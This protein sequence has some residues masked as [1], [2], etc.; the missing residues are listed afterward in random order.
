MLNDLFLEMA[1][2]I[3]TA[4]VISLLLYKLRQPLIVAY[5]ITGIIVGAS[6]LRFTETLH[7]FEILSTLGISF[8][9]FIVGLNLNWRHIRGVGGVALAGGLAQVVLSS[10]IGYFIARALH[11]DL[12]TSL[13][14]GI[15]FAFSSTIIIVKI[16]TD[17]EDIDR[18]YGRIAVGI[19]IV[20]DLLAMLSLLF[21]SAWSGGADIATVL[22][23]SLLKGV[24]AVIVLGIFSKFIIPHL[25]R[26][27]AKSQELLFL[28]ALGWCFAVASF[29][30]ILGFSVE[31]GALLA[32]VALAG[33][34]FQHE[35][36]A[37][38]RPLRDFFIIIFFIVLG[39]HLSLDSLGS[40]ALPAAVFSALVLVGNPILTMIIMRVLRHHPRT[41]FLTGTTL[42]QISEFS[43]ILITAGIAAKLVSSDALQL[44]TV[45]A[46]ITIA[47]SSYVIQYNERLF[48]ILAR[49]FP[50]LKP[51]TAEP[52]VLEEAV[53]NV[54]LIGY[55]RMGKKI[56]PMIQ[57]ISDR[58]KVIDFNPSIVEELMHYGVPVM[59]GDAGS[60]D[61]LK[62]A[63][64]DKTK[65][66]ISTIPDM[67]V[68]TDIMDFM[69]RHHARG[70]TILT[71]K[72][73]EDA[74]R[75]YALGATF[76]IVPSVLGGEH[77]AS[78]LK[79][80]GLTKTTWGTLGK[81]ELSA[82]HED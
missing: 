73:S 36:E 35:I 12:T 67:A 28:I 63:K 14:L 4:G 30:S 34:G 44:V 78:L 54:V 55:D 5:I 41:A 8:L 26:Y 76:V 68:N 1:I 25:F 80:K 72:S 2:I 61:A 20:Q 31:I 22:W 77:F 60:E 33:T 43:F 37:K 46:M 21:L 6:F 9:L 27:A 79:K 45:V 56:L 15:G 62:F 57:D 81:K 50:F 48:E 47:V 17:K 66:V 18:L 24:G 70:T 32:G 52:D 3:M 49:L 42:G 29:L 40:I 58:Y 59:Y 11:F 19:L 64:I 51:K 74:A 38:I 71:V 7:L 23:S 69:H 65:M 82:I 10:A 53:P 13:F 39:T 75:C 16:L